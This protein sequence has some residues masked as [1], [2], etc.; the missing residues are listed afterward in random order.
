MLAKF[1]KRSKI[2][3]KDYKYRTNEITED[4]VQAVTN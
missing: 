4:V 2:P 3:E 1:Y